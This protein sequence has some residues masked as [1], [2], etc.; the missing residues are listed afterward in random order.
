MVKP[1]LLLT[2]ITPSKR[3]IIYLKKC[4]LYR[5]ATF[6]GP[7]KEEIFRLQALSA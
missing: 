1:R 7:K 6:I 4:I 2:K 3:N 5:H